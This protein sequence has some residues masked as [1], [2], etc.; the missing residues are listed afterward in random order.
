[1]IRF[2][3]LAVFVAAF[4]P[5]CGEDSDTLPD[6][7]VAVLSKAKGSPV[8]LLVL[9]TPKE[10]GKPTHRRLAL[11]A[12]TRVTVLDDSREGSYK[13]GRRIV[14]VRLSEGEHADLVGYVARYKLR[15]A[16]VAAH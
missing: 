13:A 2:I 9:D 12:G 3:A 14:Q 11:P 10:D 16:S 15:A 5:G 4:V 6:G 1:M 7:S 8:E